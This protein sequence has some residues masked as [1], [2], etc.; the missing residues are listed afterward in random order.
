MSG[1]SDG[2]TGGCSDVSRRS[3]LRMTGVALG[4]AGGALGA[5]GAAAADPNRLDDSSRAG[6]AT[7]DVDARTGPRTRGPQSVDPVPVQGLT[8]AVTDEL[9]GGV[10]GFLAVIVGYAGVRLLGSD[11]ID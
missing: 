7:R 9:V 2:T 5:G 10:G 11:D 1:N 3:L 8:G 6:D 4:V